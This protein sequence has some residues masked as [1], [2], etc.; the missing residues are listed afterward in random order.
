LTRIAHI[1]LILTSACPIAFVY[2][3][4]LVLQDPAIAAKLLAFAL[5]CPFGCWGLLALAERRNEQEPKKVENISPLE[6]E[7]LGS[8]V[9]YALPLATVTAPLNSP[10]AISAACGLAAFTCVL[11]IIVWK[12]QLFYL[13][14][15]MAML[16]YRF[17]R[18][19]TDNGEPILIFTKMKGAASGNR[20][21]VRLSD[22]LWL[23][24][25]AA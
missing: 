14:P 23:D 18:A 11:L 17:Y 24:L 9:A 5:V 20:M 25:G 10:A 8:V 7:P 19:T 22:Y 15:L 4:T 13:N 21:I 3:A 6:T 12:Q 16:G 1:L 2:A